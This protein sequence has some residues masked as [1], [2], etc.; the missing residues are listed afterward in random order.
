MG[1]FG[2]RLVAVFALFLDWLGFSCFSPFVFAS[3]FLIGSVS[4]DRV[5][6]E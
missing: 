4:W 3:I 5:G 1:G 2:L 6:I